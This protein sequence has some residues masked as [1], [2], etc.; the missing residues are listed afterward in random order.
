MPERPDLEYVVPIL[1][2]ELVGRTITG[3]RTKKPVVLRILVEGSPEHLLNGQTI[4]A[5][6]R[7]AH[8]VLFDLTGPSPIELA[9]SPMLAGRFALAAPGNRAPADLAIAWT[10]SDGRELRYRDDVQMGKVYL[11]APGRWE[12]VP[13]LETV[14]VDVFDKR[15]FTRDAFR[16]LARQRRDQVKVFLKDKSALDAMGNAYADEVLWAARINPKRMTRSL[17][18]EELDRV[19]DAIV[20]VLCDATTVIAK[21][22]PPL[23]EKLR[24]FLSVRGRAGQP[25]PRCGTTI[26]TARVRA[27]DAHFCPECQP[28]TRRRPF[29]DW[30]RVSREPGAS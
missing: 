10:L 17:S 3:I 7:R 13:G 23:D 18:V 22:Q 12:Q 1:N 11:L 26:R 21:R 20:S 29:V 27:D 14:G 28:D 9:I 24:D 19:H 2:R 6:R 30:R 25:C 5:V 8:F 4:R 16:E 15:A